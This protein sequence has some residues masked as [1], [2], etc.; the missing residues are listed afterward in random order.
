MGAQGALLSPSLI[1]QDHCDHGWA[2]LH[3]E[4]TDLFCSLCLKP[5]SISGMSCPNKW[6]EDP[7]PPSPIL[8]IRLCLH[9]FPLEQRQLAVS[10]DREGLSI[11]SLFSGSVGMGSQPGADVHFGTRSQTAG[12]M[13][14]L[15][16]VFRQSYF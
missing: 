16:F 4:G 7:C 9:S 12:S 1:V 14:S 15:D 2:F 13:P 5:Q 6:K 8:P 11:N 3:L 10:R